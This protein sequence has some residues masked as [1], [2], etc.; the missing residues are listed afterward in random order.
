ME[1]V[2]HEIT[3]E[4]VDCVEFRPADRA[5]LPRVQ[6]FPANSQSNAHPQFQF[7][8]NDSEW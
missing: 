8:L 4:A 2:N 5:L 7:K 3:M 1:S 6:P